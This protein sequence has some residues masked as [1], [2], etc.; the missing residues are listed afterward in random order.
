LV[1][2]AQMVV[3]RCNW[4]LL[5]ACGWGKERRGGV[6][7]SYR[8][9]R[10]VPRRRFFGGEVAGGQRWGRPGPV[11][12]RQDGS[13]RGGGCRA[14]DGSRGGGGWDGSARGVAV[15]GGGSWRRCM[16]E[17]TARAGT[18]VVERQGRISSRARDR[19]A[20]ALA[21][22]ACGGGR[23]AGLRGHRGQRRQARCRGRAA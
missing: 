15:I 6:P 14:A 4:V 16:A 3:W 11:A 9:R 17:A 2:A 21:V 5:E 20:V 19:A 10:S 13:G 23:A 8:P 12:R 1:A 22:V 18:E 7:A